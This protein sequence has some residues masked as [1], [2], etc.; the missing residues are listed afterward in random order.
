MLLA[1]PIVLYVIRLDVC[2]GH[3]TIWPNLQ[4]YDIL[5]SILFIVPFVNVY[6]FDKSFKSNQGFFGSDGISLVGLTSRQ[7]KPSSG[8]PD[9]DGFVMYQGCLNPEFPSFC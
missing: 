5:V 9:F 4:P 6:Y 1:S 7:S 3:A 8:L 2:V